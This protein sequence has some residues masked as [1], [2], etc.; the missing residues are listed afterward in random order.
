MTDSTLVKM[1]TGTIA[2]LEHEINSAPEVALDKGSVYFAVDTTKHIGKIVYD[3]PDGNGGVDR[4][5]M[6]TYDDVVPGG[7]SGLMTGAQA[8]KLQGIAAGAEVN[9]NAFSNIKIGSTTIAADGKTDTFELVG[10]NVSLTPDASNDKITIGINKSNI[11]SALGYTPPTTNTTYEKATSGAD[12]LMSKEDKAAFDR[13]ITIAGNIVAVGG[14]L[15]ANTLVSSLGLSNALHFIGKAGVDIEDESTTDP[16]ISGY[17]VATDRKAGDVIIDRNNSRE[18]VWTA[19]GAWEELGPDGSYSLVDHVHSIVEPGSSTTSGGFMSQSDKQKLNGI[20]NGATKTTISA[21]EPIVASASTGAVTLTHTASGPNNTNTS[22]G[23]T[24]AQTP[25][26]GQTFKVTSGTVDKY[27]HTTAFADHTVTIP[28][29]EASSENKGLMTASQATKLQGIQAGA[30]VNK[31]NSIKMNNTALTITDKAVN[32]PV[33]G[34]A[35]SSANGTAG[36][37]PAP[38]K[39]KQT[40]FLRG[41]GSWEVPTDTTYNTVSPGGASDPPGLMTASDKAKLDGIHTGATE[42]SFSRSLTTGTQIGT[43]TINNTAT[44]L[45]STNDTWIA[46]KGATSSAAGTVGYINAA[47][48]T[49]QTLSYFAGNGTWRGV[50]TDATGDMGLMSA[51]MLTKL[52]GIEGGANKYTHPSYTAATAAAKKVGRDSS[53]HVVLGDSLTKGDVGLSNVTNDAQIAKSIGTAKGDIIYFSSS[54]TPTKLAIGQS[55]QVLKVN[56]SGLPAWSSDTDT[57]TKVSVQTRGTTKSYLMADTTAPTNT[58]TAHTAVAETGIYMTTT[59]GELNAT[60]YKVNEAV[61]L[62]YNSTTK[63]L[64]FIFA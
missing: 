29:T 23:D 42:V 18:Y 64:D 56:S 27:G 8:T 2:K 50:V 33:M 7:A 51:A 45:Y 59:A 14:Q 54:G 44:T 35:S 46:F 30:E 43:I 28:A 38:T 12:G 52:N 13:G 37:V 21:T 41:D 5:V 48:T 20:A 15:A 24:T 4:I 47:P 6:S 60:Q 19:A 39:G 16:Q 53:G 40:S 63:S 34:A 10:S 36:V 61:T 11:V 58:A 17:T 22:K 57:D 25:G 55:G 49:A 26:F 32:I 31:I 62:Q 9:Q 1:K 3:A